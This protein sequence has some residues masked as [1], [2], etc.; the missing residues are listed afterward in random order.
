[1]VGDWL[2]MASYNRPGAPARRFR[3]RLSSGTTYTVPARAS[4]VIVA[5][6]NAFSSG[7]TI[8]LPPASSGNIGFYCTIFVAVIQTGTLKI[9]SAADGD[10]MYGGIR[11][12]SSAAKADFFPS[13]ADGSNDAIVIDAGNKGAGVGTYFIFTL[14]G[15][16]KWMV[17]AHTNCTGT[18]ADPWATS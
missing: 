2:L 17:Q 10:S 7:M 11:A 9:Q 12:I 14:V 16:D 5:L 18:P 15:V 3:K 6:T 8:T 1:M 4:G 13:A